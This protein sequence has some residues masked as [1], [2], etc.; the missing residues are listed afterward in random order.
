MNNI[1]KK[2]FTLMELLIV[3]VLLGFL[4]TAGVASYSSSLTKSRDTK[5]K[6][7]LRQIAITLEAYNNDIG[8]YPLGDSNGSIVGCNGSACPW[9]G[10]FQNATTLYMVTLPGDAKSTQRYF[11]VS[12]DGTYFQLYTRLENTK[13][14]DIPRLGDKPRAFNGVYCD[15]PAGSLNCNYGVASSNIQVET[16]HTPFIYE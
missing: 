13:D 6:N 3:I 1:T 12:P 14:S 16:G 15:N 10:A 9:G 4:V 5:R 8:S 7:D 2:G 11:Y